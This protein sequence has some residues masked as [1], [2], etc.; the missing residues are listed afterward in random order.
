VR[1]VSWNLW[2][3]FGGNWRERQPRIIATLRE[4]RADVVG[5]QEVWVGGGT[6][7]AEVLASEPGLHS[8]VATPSLPPPP[9]P[10]ESPDQ[11]DVEVGVAVLSRWPVVEEREHRLPSVNR[12]PPP[13]A[14]LATLGHPAGPL[15]VVVSCVEWEPAFVDDHLAQTRALAELVA[16]PALDGPLPVLLVGDLNAPPD[17]PQ[18]RTLTDV[19]VDTW[20][21][22]GGDGD[23]ITLSS[24]NPYA[25]TNAW[26]QMDRRIDYVLARP[27]HREARVSVERAFIA[28]R[29]VDGPPPSDH[30]AVVADL[31]E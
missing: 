26:A 11:A 2:W 16:D 24:A 31:S 3:R 15:H 7:Q 8:A 14:L 20:V 12:T 22:G 21:A 29:P 4:L 19:M 23:D 1:I 17:T 18:I 27:G 9:R 6:S 10:V 13:V 30:Y 25:Q 28:G 5:L